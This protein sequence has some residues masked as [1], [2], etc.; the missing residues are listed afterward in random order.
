MNKKIFIVLLVVLP[1]VFLVVHSQLKSKTPLFEVHSEHFTTSTL[2]EFLEAGQTS[3]PEDADVQITE[4]GLFKKSH[5]E[6]FSEYITQSSF[7]EEN[8]EPS[9][10]VEKNQDGIITHVLFSQKV[11]TGKEREVQNV[12]ADIYN[13]K[14]NS[15]TPVPLGPWDRYSSSHNFFK[16]GT[17]PCFTLGKKILRNGKIF[18]EIGGYLAPSEEHGIYYFDGTGWNFLVP[19]ITSVLNIVDGRGYIEK[20]FVSLDGCTL[21]AKLGIAPHSHFKINI[22]EAMRTGVDSALLEEIPS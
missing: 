2:E 7:G 15:V 13:L 4:L 14:N 1:F 20:F 11:W 22:C 3:E 6:T 18:Q 5:P 8:F 17:G 12:L 9:V 21:H 16:C 19:K 10:Y